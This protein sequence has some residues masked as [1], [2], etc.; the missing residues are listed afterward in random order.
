MAGK[1]EVLTVERLR[2]VLDYDPASGVF[3]WRVDTGKKRLAGTVAGCSTK[4]GHA[5][6]G[7]DGRLYLAHR[8]AWMWVNGQ[9][10]AEEIDH[11]NGDPSDNRITNLREASH[12]Q[13]MRNSSIRSHNTTGFKGVHFYKRT[14]AWTAKVTAG[15]RQHFLGYFR[16]AQDAHAAY[17]AAA[18][19]VHGEFHRVR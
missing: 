17:V 11:R 18:V 13:N 5:V 15:G 7:I 2:A 3:R 4:T 19:R 8:L 10:P 9:W 14:G 12:A 1:G 6:I 16:S